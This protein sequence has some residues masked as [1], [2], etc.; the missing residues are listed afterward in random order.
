MN[1][2]GKTFDAVLDGPRLSSQLE[3]V[4]AVLK[5]GQWITLRML[6]HAV[7]GSEASVSARIRDMRKEK[8]G[9]FHIERRRDPKD[10]SSGVWQ[11]R[12]IIPFDEHGQGILI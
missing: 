2:E 8:F 12:L 10:P 9:G 5:N 4:K 7:G 11:Y 6:A 3:R 1:F